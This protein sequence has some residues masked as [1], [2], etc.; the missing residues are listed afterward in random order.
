MKKVMASII[1]SAFVLG[2]LPTSAQV[3]QEYLRSQIKQIRQESLGKIKDLRKELVQVKRGTSTP[4]VSST[5][6]VSLMELNKAYQAQQK[7]LRTTFDLARTKAELE[8]RTAI[9]ALNK[10]Q[11]A[12]S[13]LLRKNR[14]EDF[15]KAE[16]N[17]KIGRQNMKLASTSATT[18]I[19]QLNK[20]RNDDYRQ[21]QLEHQR[22]NKLVN[23]QVDLAHKAINDKFQ[24][25]M[26]LVKTNFETASKAAKIDFET[27]RKQLLGQ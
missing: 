20:K 26:K 4:L 6:R 23:T 5:T 13:T 21:A 24:A 7:T 10:S 27:K 9:N 22:D 8:K 14:T 3:P 11:V 16:Q 2:A 1:A 15:R 17:F 18:T 19:R 25:D 12:S